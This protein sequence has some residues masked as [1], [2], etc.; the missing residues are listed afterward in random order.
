MGNFIYTD[1]RKRSRS[2]STHSFSA[3]HFNSLSATVRLTAIHVL[4]FWSSWY[5]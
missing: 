1:L 4:K 2:I 3:S 5:T